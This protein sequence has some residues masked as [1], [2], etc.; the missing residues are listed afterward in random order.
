MSEN[1]TCL[2]I[3]C[4]A[5]PNDSESYTNLQDSMSTTTALKTQVV[6]TMKSLFSMFSYYKTKPSVIENDDF[7]RVADMV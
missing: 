2:L 1:T 6:S 5:I 7:I 4:L 3:T